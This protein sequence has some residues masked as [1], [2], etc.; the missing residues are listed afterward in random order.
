MWSEMEL[1]QRWQ[2]HVYHALTSPVVFNL[3]SNLWNHVEF[4]FLL[5]MVIIVPMILTPILGIAQDWFYCVFMSY[6]LWPKIDREKSEKSSRQFYLK[7]IWCFKNGFYVR[8]FSISFLLWRCFQH[9]I[10]LYQGSEE[11]P[12]KMKKVGLIFQDLFNKLASE[13]SPASL[14]NLTSSWFKIYFEQI[15]S[16]YCRSLDTYWIS[17]EFRCLFDKRRRNVRYNVNFIRNGSIH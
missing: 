3:D 6:K 4:N 16:F 17:H 14:L 10:L 9:F 2:C 1:V 11:Q 13:K 7:I 8:W 15:N 12:D 5:F